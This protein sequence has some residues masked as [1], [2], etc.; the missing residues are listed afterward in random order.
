MDIIV[1]KFGGTSVAN[2]EKL[3]IVSKKIMKLHDEGHSVVVVVSAQGKKNGQ[4]ATR[5]I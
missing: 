1:L 3:N 4:F 2:N 5:S